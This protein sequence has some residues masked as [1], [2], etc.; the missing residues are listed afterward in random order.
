[1]LSKLGSA[2]R[3]ARES[4]ELSLNQGA[5]QANI[6]NAYLHKLEHG[7]VNTPSPRVLARV[8]RVLEI[9]YLNLME[10]AGYLDATEAAA[11]RARKPTPRPHPLQ[12]Q[13][14]S[15]EEWKAVGAFIKTLKARR[16]SVDIPPLD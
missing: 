14:L 2:L 6:S 15:H 5:K 12:G 3:Q 4:K 8:A 9:P 7:R 11:A 10:M 16:A 1:M 13:D